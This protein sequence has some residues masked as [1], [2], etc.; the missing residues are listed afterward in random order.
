MDPNRRDF[1]AV[2]TSAAALGTRADAKE[3]QAGVTKAQPSPAE[4]DP[5]AA[6]FCDR[7]GQTGRSP[8]FCE[9]EYGLAFRSA[10]R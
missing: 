8:F 10:G 6:K 5:A 7:W 4:F 3:P 1:L 9:R 2:G